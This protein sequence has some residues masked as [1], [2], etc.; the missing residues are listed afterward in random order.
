M[1]ISEKEWGKQGYI[2]YK[3]CIIHFLKIQFEASEKYKITEIK[4]PFNLNIFSRHKWGR[5]LHR[6]WQFGTELTRHK[7]NSIKNVCFY[8]V[9]LRLETDKNF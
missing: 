9:F 4:V 5:D 7:S 1:V 6:S 2:G 3:V 8:F